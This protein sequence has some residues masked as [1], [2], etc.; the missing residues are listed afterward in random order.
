MGF[1]VEKDLTT[2]REECTRK[3]QQEAELLEQTREIE[4][5]HKACELR[6]HGAKTSHAAEQKTMTGR[7]ARIEEM[8]AK[9][10]GTTKR[11]AGLERTKD[12]LQTE[13]LKVGKNYFVKLNKELGVD[14]MRDIIQK[15]QREKH[16]LRQD[17]EQYE[18][19]IRGLLN[20]ERSI[21]QRM[22][23]ASKLESMTAV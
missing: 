7:T 5:R 21:E 3:Q 8:K 11:L 2:L 4:E 16:M 13:L 22:K 12:A 9:V 14:D 6:L 20:E 10:E 18:D 17:I 1:Q 19:Y 15:E 23:G